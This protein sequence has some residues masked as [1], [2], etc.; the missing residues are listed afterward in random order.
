MEQAQQYWDS[1]YNSTFQIVERKCN[2]VI[3]PC[4][5]DHAMQIFLRKNIPYNYCCAVHRFGHMS[6]YAITHACACIYAHVYAHCLARMVYSNL[7]ASTCQNTSADP[8]VCTHMFTRA[9]TCSAFIPHTQ[10][11]ATY[12]YMC[13]HMLVH[14][15]PG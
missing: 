14:S 10:A 6:V 2:Q 8:R 5:K 15:R 13:R 3:A 12:L 1:V 7:R 4:R 9:Y 11:S